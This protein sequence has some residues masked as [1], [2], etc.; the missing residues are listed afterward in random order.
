VK[1]HYLAYGSNL[2]PLRL[3]ERVPSSILQGQLCLPG[4]RLAFHKLGQ[5][6]SGKCNIIKTDKQDDWV[7]AAL[8]ELDAG[9]KT[10]LDGFEGA[11]YAVEE[12]ALEWQ[13]MSIRPFIY[14][15]EGNW[16]D[17]GLLP[18][19][20]YREIVGLGARY[21]GLADEYIAFIEGQ[22]S[23]QDPVSE[24]G[25]RHGQLIERMRVWPGAVDL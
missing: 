17:D 15:A 20:W 12:M 18:Y 1:H 13:G 5:D 6:G 10:L 9:E 2:H 14:I 8:F 23:I 25:H 4:Y 7:H 24:R 22:A 19:H 16:I 3:R 21:H 11:G